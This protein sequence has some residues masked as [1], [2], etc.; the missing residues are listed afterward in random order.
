M[1]VESRL[2]TGEERDRR[3]LRGRF[4]I[5]GQTSRHRPS[6]L[7]YETNLLCTVRVNSCLGSFVVPLLPRMGF[8][9]EPIRFRRGGDASICATYIQVKT[10]NN[11]G[12]H[13]D[14]QR[15]EKEA[16]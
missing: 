10:R 7:T 3:A 6:Q 13:L 2:V 14:D 5:G 8:D 12:I 9:L 1:R 11:W 4:R 15:A 16:L